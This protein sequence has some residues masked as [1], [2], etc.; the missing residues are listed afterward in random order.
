MGIDYGPGSR[1]SFHLEARG[2]TITRDVW[3]LGTFGR[4]PRGILVVARYIYIYIYMM[5]SGEPCDGIMC[6]SLSLSFSLSSFSPS[7]FSVIALY[8]Y[9]AWQEYTQ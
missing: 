7:V 8:R 2:F 4:N 5:L 3:I 6:L 9:I 1:A